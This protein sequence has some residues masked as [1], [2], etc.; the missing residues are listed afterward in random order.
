MVLLGGKLTLPAYVIKL[1]GYDPDL[2]E[3]LEDESHE[4]LMALCYVMGCNKAPSLMKDLN[5]AYARG[6]DDFPKTMNDAISLVSNYRGDKKPNS[7]PDQKSNKEAQTAVGFAQKGR[8]SQSKK[9]KCYTCGKE[10]HYANECTEVQGTLH[11]QQAAESP[12]TTE[13]TN[14][15]AAAPAPAPAPVPSAFPGGGGRPRSAR[16]TFGRQFFHV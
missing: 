12:A 14:D 6:H 10:G 5:N 1:P 9:G 15:G 4:K 8:Q 3:E 7:K 2:H 13:N 11:A 16:V